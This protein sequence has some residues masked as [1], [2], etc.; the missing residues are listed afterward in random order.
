MNVT[1]K[2]TR[3]KLTGAVHRL[4]GEELAD[5]FRAFGRADLEPVTVDVEVEHTSRRYRDRDDGR[6]YRAEATR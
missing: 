1:Y 6:P 5:A 4:L 3:I 2:G